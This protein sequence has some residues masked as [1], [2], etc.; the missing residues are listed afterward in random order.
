MPPSLDWKRGGKRSVGTCKPNSVR[1]CRRGDH[2]SRPG[3]ATRLQR[4]T[5]RFGEP[6]RLAG[7]W[8]APP[9]IPPY[10][11]LLRVGFTKRRP[12]L[13]ARCAL[14]A[15]FHPYPG[16]W[17][18]IFSV[19]LAVEWPLS[20]PPGRYP[21]HCSAEFGLSS[22]RGAPSS[23]SW[24]K[25][26]GRRSPGPNAIEEIIP[27]K[28]ISPYLPRLADVGYPYMAD[29]EPNQRRELAASKGTRRTRICFSR[30]RVWAMS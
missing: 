9:P 19:A 12:L 5:R 1:R 21:A 11:V 8:L 18:G 23:R 28:G 26:H 6:S 27:W 10:L 14:T 29:A 30:L 17:G 16:L 22:P 20:H 25:P 15:P 4:P 3:V 24:R 7:Q 13:N 2:S